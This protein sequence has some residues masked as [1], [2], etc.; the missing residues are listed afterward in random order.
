VAPGTSLQR[1]PANK[2]AH[3]THYLEAI[4]LTEIRPATLQ[5]EGQAG[6]VIGWSDGHRRKYTAA[7]LR[8]ACPCATCREKKSAE[9]KPPQGSNLKGSLLPVLSMQEA[10]PTEIEH[11]RP[12]G[13]Y[14]YN[15]SFSDGH[16]SGIFTFNYLIELGELVE[17]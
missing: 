15:I 16:D 17:A 7:G 3:Q 8:A 2:R 9:S 1:S 10:R 6:L 4:T 13:N 12:V 5:R 14:A 11:M